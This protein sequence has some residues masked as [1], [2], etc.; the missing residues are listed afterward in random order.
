MKGRGNYLCLHRFEQFKSEGSANSEH[1]IHLTL[2]D[3]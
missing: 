3:E 2:L 1:R